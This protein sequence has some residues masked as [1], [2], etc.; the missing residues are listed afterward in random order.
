MCG[1][2]YY[3][4]YCCG[5]SSLRMGEVAFRIMIQ[6]YSL[7]WWESSRSRNNRQLVL[8]HPQSGGREGWI[9][10]LSSLYPF[11]SLLDSSPHL[12][13]RESSSATCTEV[14]CVSLVILDWSSCQNLLIIVTYGI[15]GNIEGILIYRFLGALLCLRCH[16]LYYCAPP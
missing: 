8:W 2:I 10:L 4:C 11:H 5:K 14:W 13:C 3:L 15:D 9:L 7:S 1:H 12:G 16:L 6:G